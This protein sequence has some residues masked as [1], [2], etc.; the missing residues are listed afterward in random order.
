MGVNDFSLYN[1]IHRNSICFKDSAFWY[2]VDSD[3]S[4]TFEVFKQK[5]DFLAAGLQKAGIRKGDRIAVLGKNSL[6]LFLLYGAAAALGAIILPVNWRLSSEEI[7]I[8]LNDGGPKM[9]FVDNEYEP[10]IKGLKDGLSSVEIYGS[11]G[12]SDESFLDFAGFM[13][14]EGH[15]DPPEVS[16]DDGFVIIYTAAVTGI[17]RGALLTHGNILSSTTQ[18]NYFVNVRPGDVNLHILPLFHVGGLIGAFA[19]FQAGALNVN[20]KKFDAKEAL[21]IIMSK[22]VSIIIEF[23]PI[24]SSI[25]NETEKC[26]ANINCLRAVIGI[27]TAEVIERYETISGGIFYAT[28]GQTETSANATFGIYRERPGSA[29]KVAPFVDLQVVDEYDSPV[30]VGDIGEITTRGPLVFKGYWNLPEESEY[31]FRNG[32]HHTGDL[33]RLD[34]DGFVWYEG[35]KSEKELIKPGGE[36]VYPAE[37][38]RVILEHPAIERTVV[39]GV[40]D[41]KWKE[42]IKALCKLKTGHSLEPKELIEFVGERIARFKKPQYV[43]FIED[44]PLLEDETPDRKKIKQ[45]YGGPQQE[46]VLRANVD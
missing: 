40:P 10:V 44:F 41:P 42:G 15:F 3:R 20:L 14:T 38:E 13:D 26:G 33:G 6:E 37:V 36:N 46:S 11:I 39:F 27:D 32:W 23:A 21:E 24:L 18:F 16:T 19:A 2:E 7:L 28:Y 45:L 25:L 22:K 35:C 4:L 5:V 43:Q 9:L 30:P 31:T 12:V 29:G 34:E 1:I 17:P 8:N